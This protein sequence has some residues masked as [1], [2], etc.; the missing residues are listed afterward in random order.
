MAEPDRLE[1]L[2]KLMP[3]A[4]ALGVALDAAAPDE[5]RARLEWRADLC[6]A[7]GVMHGGAVMTLADTVGAL[8]AF[9]NLPEG[10]NT[11]TVES[12][13]NFFRGLREGTLHATARPLNVGRTL[14]VVKTSLLDGRE[15]PIG[16]TV[17]TQ[18]VLG[19]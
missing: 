7:G 8:C 12:K 3:H 16:H 1:E 10:A 13:T 19:G 11:A 4:V 18:A 2:L 9:L 14:I 5:V 17:Q 15:R 6:T